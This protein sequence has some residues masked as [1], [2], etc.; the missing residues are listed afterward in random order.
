VRR[1]WFIAAI[2]LGIV[3]IAVAA[4]LMRLTEDDNAQASPS[5]WADSVC[6][7]LATWRS[8]ITAI[9][10]VSG[11]TLTPESLRQSLGDAT[12]ATETLVTDLR[13]LGPPDLDA[14]EELKQ[15]LDSAASEIEAGFD[16]LKQ[17]AEDAANAG[18]PADFIQ[19]LAALA[20]SRP[21]STRCRRQST[22]SGARTSPGTHETSWTRRSRARRRAKSCE[23]TVKN[24]RIRPAGSAST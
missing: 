24:T 18:S 21:C 2:V 13:Q 23:A 20:S 11:E 17:G 15:Q 9:S 7:S 14:G 16:A 10:D 3:S 6:T 12:T 8:S 4:V 19:A 5:A 22:T 1:S